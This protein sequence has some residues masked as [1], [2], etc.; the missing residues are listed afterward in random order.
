MTWV[1]GATT[2]FGHGVVVSDTRVTC[3][4]TGEYQDILR[5]TYCVGKYLVAGFAGDVWAGFG[6]LANLTKLL[7]PP[8]MPENE[9]WKPQ[10]VAE[11]WPPIAC[12]SFEKLS[13]DKP[14]G[15]TH[16]L[17]VGAEESPEGSFPKSAPSICVFRSPL[18]AP[19]FESGLCKANSIGCGSDVEEYRSGLEYLVKDPEFVYVRGELWRSGGQGIMIANMIQHIARKQPADGVSQQF[20][21]SLIGHGEIQQWDSHGMNQVATNWSTLLELLNAGM[22]SGC[23]TA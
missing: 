16:I 18:F 15:E 17:M 22:D 13:K 14:V 23:L 7:N 3:S 12:Q 20:H 8:D 1:I 4:S 5:K 6:L 21:Y 19:E 9:Y 11:N 10:W 2:M